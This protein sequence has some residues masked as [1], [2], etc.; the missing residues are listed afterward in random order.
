MTQAKQA[1][2][3]SWFRPPVFM[4]GQ[5][6]RGNWVVQDQ[7]V[8]AGG[9]SWIVMRHSALCAQRTDIAPRL[10]ESIDLKVSDGSTCRI[11]SG[12]RRGSRASAEERLKSCPPSAATSRS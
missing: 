2:P 8:S 4:I 3:P 6:S 11:S 1:E 10:S 9:Y 12:Q 5:N 7:K